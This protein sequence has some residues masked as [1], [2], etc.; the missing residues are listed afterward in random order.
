MKLTLKP[1]G[2]MERLGFATGKFPRLPVMSLVGPLLSQSLTVAV[3]LGVFDRMTDG[4]KNSTDLAHLTNCDPHAMEIFLEGLNSFGVLRRKGGMFSLTREARQWLTTGSGKTSAIEAIQLNSEI[5]SRLVHLEEYLKTGCVS[6]IHFES[7]QN[8]WTNYLSA[9]KAAGQLGASHLLRRLRLERLPKTM[10]DIGGGPAIWS[11]AFCKHFEGLTSTIVELPEI[12]QH[13]LAMIAQ[14]DMTD[15]IRYIPG[16]FAIADF[17]NGYDLVLMSNVLHAMTLS[18]CRNVLAKAY[19]ALNSNGTLVINDTYYP[20]SGGNIPLMS[21]A[22]SLMYYVS[23]GS[24]SWPHTSIVEWLRITGFKNIQCEARR[25]KNL[26]IT[27]SSAAHT[28]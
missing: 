4:A 21:G 22:S 3:R 19:L 11:I 8:W 18:Q 7:S 24:R 28:N 26:F 10:L 2:L 6:N 25:G 14:A 27:A 9:L 1:E 20:S 23:T 16:D 17:G 5:C 12:A 13:G 15:R